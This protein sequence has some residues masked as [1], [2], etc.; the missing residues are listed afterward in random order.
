MP[1]ES[2]Q[3]ILCHMVSRDG[4]RVTLVSNDRVCIGSLACME[5]NDAMLLCEVIACTQDVQQRWHLELNIEQ[6]LTGLQSLLRLRQR[7]VNQSA[8]SQTE[9]ALAAGAHWR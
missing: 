3:D 7:L 1:G 4:K 5:Y 8:S 9:S 2:P 6:V